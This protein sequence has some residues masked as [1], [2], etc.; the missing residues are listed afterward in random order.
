LDPASAYSFHAT[1]IGRT[2]HR[3]WLVADQTKETKG[4]REKRYTNCKKD[5][6]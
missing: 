5:G 3:V 1:F 6:Y 2:L 4:K